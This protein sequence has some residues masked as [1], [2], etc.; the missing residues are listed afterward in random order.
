MSV[1]SPLDL[2]VPTMGGHDVDGPW[3][4]LSSTSSNPY[5]KKAHVDHKIYGVRLKSFGDTNWSLVDPR[6]DVS[7]LPPLNDKE[8]P[9]YALRPKLQKRKDPRSADLKQENMS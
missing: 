1:S 5:N 9:V 2:V 3:L 4:S 6:A 7:P 8:T